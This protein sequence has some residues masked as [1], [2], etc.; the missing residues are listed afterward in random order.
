MS[1]LDLKEWTN[2]RRPVVGML[3]APALPGSPRCGGDFEGITAAVLRDAEILAGEGVHAMMLENFGDVP[4]R[5]RRGR[6]WRGDF[7]TRLIFHLGLMCSVMTGRP[8]WRW[9][10]AWGLI[11]FGSMCCAERV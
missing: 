4:R 10:R 6:G 9:R 1:K 8:R 7:G 5:G 2:R 11:L 3:H